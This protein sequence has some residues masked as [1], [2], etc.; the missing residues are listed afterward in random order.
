MFAT[1]PN[2]AVMSKV[3]RKEIGMKVSWDEM[4]YREDQN[5]LKE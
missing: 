4:F 3:E 5:C 1:R 2:F